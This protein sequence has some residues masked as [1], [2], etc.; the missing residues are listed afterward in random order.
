VTSG[1]RVV[2]VRLGD[3]QE[4]W[5]EAVVSGKGATVGSPIVVGRTVYVVIRTLANMGTLVRLDPA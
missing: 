3:G 5:S 2:V 4:V 1:S